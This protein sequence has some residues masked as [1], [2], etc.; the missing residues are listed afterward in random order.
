MQL[1]NAAGTFSGMARRKPAPTDQINFRLK[2]ETIE[3]LERYRDEYPLNPS[4]TRIVETALAEWFARNPLPDAK[5]VATPD[6]KA[7]GARKR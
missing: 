6:A 2:V 5:S 7:P 3:T 4:M 1:L